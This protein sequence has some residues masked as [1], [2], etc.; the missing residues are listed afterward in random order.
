MGRKKLRTSGYWRRWM[1]A[2]ALLAVMFAAFVIW[3]AW[4]QRWGLL[5]LYLVLMLWEMGQVYL[6]MQKMHDAEE[7]ERV[8]TRDDPR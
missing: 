8:L 5:A 3:D 4:S 2:D 6:D 1:Y 7:R